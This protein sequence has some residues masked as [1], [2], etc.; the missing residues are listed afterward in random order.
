M[1]ITYTY[2]NTGD[3]KGYGTA[4]VNNITN[5]GGGD[6]GPEAGLRGKTKDLQKSLPAGAIQTHQ[7]HQVWL[8][9]YDVSRDGPRRGRRQPDGSLY[10]QMDV[11]SGSPDP[12]VERP[13]HLQPA[14]YRHKPDRHAR[15]RNRQDRRHLHRRALR[16]AGPPAW[17]DGGNPVPA[18]VSNADFSTP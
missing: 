9:R 10:L 4:I 16:P 6:D 5:S 14:L 13:G 3:P 2:G 11:P 1:T 17:E 15:D 7:W 12:E 8:C 18:A